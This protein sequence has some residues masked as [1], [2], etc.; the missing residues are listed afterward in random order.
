MTKDSSEV[1]EWFPP[2][3]DTFF[4]NAVAKHKHELIKSNDPGSS[5]H[6]FQW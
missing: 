3:C 5:H 1:S 2:S 4:E 6:T